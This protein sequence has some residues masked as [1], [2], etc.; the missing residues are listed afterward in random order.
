[1]KTIHLHTDGGSRGNP[2]PAALGVVLRDDE[3]ND[4]VSEGRYIGI[5]TNNVAEYKALVRALELSRELEADA[6]HVHMDSELIVKQMTGVYRI[7]HKDMKPLAAAAKAL[8]VEF[9]EGVTYVHVPREENKDADAQVNIALD[10][11]LS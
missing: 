5:A 3:G 10:E 2:G 11:Q 9:P 8:E 4:L 7:K 1:M 6:V